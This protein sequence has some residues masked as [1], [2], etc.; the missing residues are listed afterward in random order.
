MITNDRQNRMTRVQAEKFEQAI[1]AA[2]EARPRRGIDPRVHVAMI[3]AMESDLK[4]LNKQLTRYRRVSDGKVRLRRLRGLE[5]L[6]E[7]LIEARIA[8]HWTQKDLAAK[9][10]VKEQQVQRY[11]KERYQTAS[12]DRIVEVAAALGVRWESAVTLPARA[13]P[14]TSPVRKQTT[15]GSPATSKASSKAATK[16]T[17]QSTARTMPG[18]NARTRTSARGNKVA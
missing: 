4:D 7:A 10:G 2:R 8:R 6:P 18:R 17:P 11:E 15:V 3:E 5:G 9:L 1:E 12:L 16:V 13:K 14:A